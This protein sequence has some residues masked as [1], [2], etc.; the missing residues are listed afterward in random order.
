MSRNVTDALT[1]VLA[2]ILERGSLVVARGQERS[3]VLSGHP[4]RPG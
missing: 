4:R 2:D 1:D 3:S